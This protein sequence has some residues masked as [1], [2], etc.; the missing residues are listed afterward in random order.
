MT[1]FISILAIVW[2]L[3]DEWPARFAFAEGWKFRHKS[4]EVANL[5]GYRRRCFAMY[6]LP[7]KVDVVLKRYFDD[8][9]RK[10]ERMRI[11]WQLQ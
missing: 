1:L 4:A 10:T 6:A 9:W 2:E 7:R 3:C 11:R 8:N 5:F